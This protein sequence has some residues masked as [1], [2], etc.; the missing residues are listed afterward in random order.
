LNY[1]YLAKITD[2]VSREYC[3]IAAYNGG[4]GS[5]LKTFSRDRDRA[6]EKINRMHPGDVYRT[7]VADLPA[8][9][10]RRYVQKVVSAKKEF[11]KL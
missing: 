10:T 6:P 8:R 4:A 9:E 3:V 11:V 7:L 1:K 2:P 5:V